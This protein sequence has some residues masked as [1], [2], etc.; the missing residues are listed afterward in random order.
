MFLGKGDVEAV[1]AS[2]GID[3]TLIKKC[4]ESFDYWYTET[5]RHSG[6]DLIFNHLTMYIFNHVAIFDKEYWPKQIVVNALVNYEGEKM[7]KSLGNI[8]PADGRAREVRRGP[9]RV[10][11]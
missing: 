8:V 3:Y 7:S 5:S 2:T 4:R 9:A 6:P 1:A 10:M 11:R